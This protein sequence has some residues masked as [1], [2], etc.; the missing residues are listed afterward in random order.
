MHKCEMPVE[1]FMNPYIIDTKTPFS[2]DQDRDI[3]DP[4]KNELYYFNG[5]WWRFDR[6]VDV[7]NR[8]VTDTDRFYVFADNAYPTWADKRDKWIR[9]KEWAK[10]YQAQAQ[11]PSRSLSPVYRS[12]TRARD[13]TTPPR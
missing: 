13:K 5:K 10:I 8:V 4:I 12:I 1:G 9:P 7:H 11:A 2:E 3:P 6:R